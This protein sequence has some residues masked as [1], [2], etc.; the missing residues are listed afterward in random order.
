MSISA[1]AS[2]VTKFASDNSPIILTSVGVVGAVTTAVLAATGGFKASLYLDEVRR[3]RLEAQLQTATRVDLPDFKEKAKLTWMYYAPAAGTTVLTCG[4]IIA[5]HQIGM[6]RT[7]AVAAAFTLSERAMAE[8]RDKVVEHFGEKKEQKVRDSIVQDRVTQSPVPSSLV[9]VNG[10][11]ALCFDYWSARYFTSS[12]EDLKHAQNA[13]NHTILSKSFDNTAS[14]TDF[15]NLI[16]L[17]PTQNSDDLGWN[18]DKLLELEF[19]SCL[20]PDQE[21]AI[22]IKFRVEPMRDYFRSS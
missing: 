10:S 20:S 12:M 4:A 8:Y 16:G 3:E 15:Y 21:P 2:Q 5:A 7:A 1:M 9:V 17:E 11:K 18:V 22:A 14:L 19:T 6:R 13:L